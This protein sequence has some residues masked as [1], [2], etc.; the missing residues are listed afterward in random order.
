MRVAKNWI[1]TMYKNRAAAPIHLVNFVENWFGYWPDP[2]KNWW[3]RVGNNNSEYKND[4][5]P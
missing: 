3:M 5:L 1:P 4:K 2:N